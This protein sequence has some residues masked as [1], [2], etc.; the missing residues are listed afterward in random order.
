[1]ETT[2]GDRPYKA[3]GLSIDELFD[4]IDDTFKRGGNVVFPAFFP[5]FALE[6]AQELLSWARSRPISVLRMSKARTE[7]GLRMV[8]GSAGA[9][10]YGDLIL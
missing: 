8:R 3:L 10:C 4:A 6:R 1:M 7:A 9:A 5:T 2:Y